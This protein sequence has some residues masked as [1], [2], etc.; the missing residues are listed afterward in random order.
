MMSDASRQEPTAVFVFFSDADLRQRGDRSIHNEYSLPMKKFVSA[1][2]ISKLLQEGEHAVEIKAVAMTA[3][4]PSED[5]KDRTPQLEVE[6]RK[7]DKSLKA[8]LNL[9]GFKRYDDLSDA[10][11]KSG[12]FEARGPFGYAVDIAKDSRIEDPDKTASAESIIQKLG[13]DCGIPTGKAFEENDLLGMEVGIMVKK[14]EQGQLRV[15]YTKTAASV[16]TEVHA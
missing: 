3:A 15:A 6:F 13:N 5:Y 16:K 10:D 7:G 11:K 2:N 14:N 9:K 1:N 4:E 12:K 8:W